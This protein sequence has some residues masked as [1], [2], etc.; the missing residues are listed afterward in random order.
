[1]VYSSQKTNQVNFD[2]E[3][4]DWFVKQVEKQQFDQVVDIVILNNLGRINITNIENY[5]NKSSKVNFHIVN[6]PDDINNYFVSNGHLN[7]TGHNVLA[8]LLLPI[9]K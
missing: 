7:T 5:S 3:K 9:I 1:M 2:S 4:L 8:N 6:Y